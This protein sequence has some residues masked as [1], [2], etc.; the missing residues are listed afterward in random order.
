MWSLVYSN[1]NHGNAVE[2][3]L[4]EL[5]AAIRNGSPVRYYVDYYGDG[6]GIYRDA[7]LISTP[8]GWA[9]EA[10]R[11]AMVEFLLRRG[12]KVAPD[13]GPP[14]TKPVAWAQRRGYD[15]IVK[16][17]DGYERTGRLPRRTVAE[18]RDL[19]A[20]LARAVAG[21]AAA[22]ARI[23]DRFRLHRALLWDNAPFATQVERLRRMV[24]ERLGGDAGRG[25]TR[26]DAQELVARV[27][28]YADWAELTKK[29]DAE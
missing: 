20:D 17:L 27:E 11:L 3:N 2:G 16:L 26:E 8:L 6:E 7:E 15:A 21:D 28:G 9:A 1:D 5:I 25:V 10:G 4:E 29:N 23:A 24:Q 18:Y 22:L 14:W 13:G 19:A 12:A